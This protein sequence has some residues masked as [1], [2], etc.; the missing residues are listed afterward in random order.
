MKFNTY[1][2]Y[3]CNLEKTLGSELN[4]SNILYRVGLLAMVRLLMFMWPSIEMC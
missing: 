3:T 4:P 1:S 2:K